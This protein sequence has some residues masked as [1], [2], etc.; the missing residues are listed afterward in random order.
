MAA[1]GHALA[2]WS[3]LHAGEDVLPKRELHVHER[4]EG[5]WLLGRW[6]LSGTT[7]SLPQDRFAILSPLGLPIVA[8]E[9]LAFYKATGERRPRDDEDLANLLPLLDV[10]Q[11]RWLQEARAGH[12]LGA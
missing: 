1:Y 8:P 12:G 6:S 4:G 9:A 10:H 3:H 5:S 7:A 2:L 11:S